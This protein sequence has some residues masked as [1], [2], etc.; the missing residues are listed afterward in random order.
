MTFDF[1]QQPPK[2]ATLDE[3]HKLIEGLWTFARHATEKLNLNSANSSLSPSQERFKKTTPQSKKKT[4]WEKRTL[5]YW[6]KRKQGAQQG[7]KGTG[8]SLLPRE[9]VD[10]VMPCYPGKDCPHCPG[11]IQVKH[12]C[13]RKQ[14]FDL[15]LKGINVTEY[16][17]YNG[18]CINCKKRVKGKL[19]TGLPRGILTEESLSKIVLLVAQYRLSRREVKQLLADFFDLHICIGTISNAERLVSEALTNR[20]DAIGKQVKAADHAH[21]DETSHRRSGKTEWLWVA[22]NDKVS[23]FKIFDNRAQSSAKALI[24]EGYKGMTIT[25]R[26]GAYS[27]LPPSQRQY[28]WAH[29]KRDFI[30]ISE[31]LDPKEAYIGECLS[32]AQRRIFYW[33]EQLK[34]DKKSYARLLLIRQIKRFYG[35]LKKGVQ[36]AGTTTA[37]FCAKLLRERKSL[38]HFLKNSNIDPTNNLAERNIRHFVLWRKKTF[39]TRSE[40]G[41]R[42]IE[43][44]LTVMMTA[45]QA[46]ENLI[47]ELCNQLKFNQYGLC[48]ER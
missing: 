2:P 35:Y 11:T 26:Y 16:Q 31:K 45:K 37:R 43:R 46:G 30:R 14:V 24:G 13:Q 38:W 22:C 41:N 48:N 29:L 40:R 17:V 47:Q 23:L 33:Y 25:D 44:M 10:K 28:C 21:L 34:C 5:A 7:H 3:S 32:Q 15:T 9:N 18:R 36:L 19:P 8:R 6:K 42:F 4:S 39:G 1:T 27:F 20:V 12:I